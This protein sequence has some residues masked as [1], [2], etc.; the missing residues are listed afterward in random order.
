MFLRRLGID[1]VVQGNICATPGRLATLVIN[2]HAHV[3][4]EVGSCLPF[5]P[6]MVTD[7]VE[8]QSKVWVMGDVDY[9]MIEIHLGAI[10]QDA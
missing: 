10:V 1:G 2:E 8:L 4:G 6:V 9:E 5:G 7:F 3:E